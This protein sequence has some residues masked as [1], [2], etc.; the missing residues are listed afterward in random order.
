ME[1]NC[2]YQVNLHKMFDVHKCTEEDIESK[3]LCVA[4]ADTTIAHTRDSSRKLLLVSSPTNMTLNKI[5]LLFHPP[6]KKKIIRVS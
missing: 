5:F 2:I 3:H 6:P 1:K 4:F